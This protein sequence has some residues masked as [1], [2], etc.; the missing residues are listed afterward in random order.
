MERLLDGGKG[1]AV[2]RVEPQGR[3]EAVARKEER[4]GG[5]AVGAVRAALLL[6]LHHLPAVRVGGP[7]VVR[8]IVEVDRHVHRLSRDER[9]DLS[10]DREGERALGLTEDE[11][12]EEPTSGP[13]GVAPTALG[14]STVDG[15][16]EDRRS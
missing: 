1:P 13:V 15:G 6:R 9:T 16:A 4:E 11:M 3:D 5:E 14:T 10:A 12:A 8:A 7:T 2:V